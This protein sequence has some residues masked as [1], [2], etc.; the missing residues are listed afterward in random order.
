[1]PL[2]GSNLIIGMDGGFNMNLRSV[3]AMALAALFL[4][5]GWA[6]ADQLILKDGRQYSGKFI[7]ADANVV[8][9]RIFGKPETF[10]TSDVAQIV[11]KEP[12]LVTPTAA[13]EA[14][15]AVSAPTAPPVTA[16]TAPA[17]TVPVDRAATAPAPTPEAAPAKVLPKPTVTLP[18]GTALTIR[19][20][21]TIDTDRNRVGDPFDAVLEDP[22]TL[23]S[24]VL[25]PRGAAIKG[26]IAY[27]KEAGT[28]SGQSMLILELT[29]V[30]VDNRNYPLATSDYSQAGASRGKQTAGAVGGGAALGAIIGAIAGGGKGAAIGAATGAAVGTGVQVVTRGETLKVPAET[31]LEFKLQHALVLEPR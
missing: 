27:A 11:F 26:R 17:A 29:E 23:G 14:A 25:I 8:E 13:Q 9:F 31:L 5:S 1:M 3:T 7:R 20:T 22:V 4:F 2:R 15:P 30:T 28:L 19:T 16:P 21:S 10:K 24:Q 6:L 12:E 18:E